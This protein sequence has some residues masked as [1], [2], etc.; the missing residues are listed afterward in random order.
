MYVNLNMFGSLTLNE[1]ERETNRTNIITI[2]NHITRRRLMNLAKMIPNPARLERALATPM[3]ST[4]TLDR[5]IVSCGLEYQ[6]IKLYPKNK[7]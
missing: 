5:D 3:Y 4:S 2:N 1:I 7:Q 6:D